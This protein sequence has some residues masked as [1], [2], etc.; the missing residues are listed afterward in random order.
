VKN[1]RKGLFN[2]RRG[3]HLDGGKGVEGEGMA[4]VIIT[5]ITESVSVLSWGEIEN[6]ADEFKAGDRVWDFVYGWGEVTTT[7]S[8]CENYPIKVK[9][10]YDN[11]TYS[12]DGKRSNE[13]NRTLFFAEI[14]IPES[15]LK[16][17]RP[18]LKVDDRV[19]VR[20]SEDE[21]WVP[22]YFAEWGSRKIGT[23]ADGGTS[24]S[25]AAIEYWN[26]HKLPEESDD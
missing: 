4:N 16:R 1:E 23:W 18:E 13:L 11:I 12:F 22:R 24:W 19:L 8:K 17:P 7:D 5:D 9:F 10:K 25:R 2:T 6:M 14:P 21:N 15:A 26:L 20:N 3:F